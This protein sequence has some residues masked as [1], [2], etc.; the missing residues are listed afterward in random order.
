MECREGEESL[1]PKSKS[2]NKIVFD[3]VPVWKFKLRG[4]G[5]VEGHWRVG[6]CEVGGRTC[7]K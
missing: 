2:N 1:K 3:R 7:W 5:R 6:L 4:G